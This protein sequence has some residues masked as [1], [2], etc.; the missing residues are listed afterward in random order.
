LDP[1]LERFMELGEGLEENGLE[2]G[3]GLEG[4]A[5]SNKP[6]FT[7]LSRRHYRKNTKES[8]RIYPWG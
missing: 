3:M 8:P 2:L 7:G 4:R 6:P 1:G 5:M